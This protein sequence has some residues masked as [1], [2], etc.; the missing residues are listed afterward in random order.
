MLLKYEIYANQKS[1]K[2]NERLLIFHKWIWSVYLKETDAYTRCSQFPKSIIWKWNDT[3]KCPRT[4]ITCTKL[5]GVGSRT[6]SQD[7]RSLTCISQGT[8]YHNLSCHVLFNCTIG[9]LYPVHLL[10]Y[11]TSMVKNKTG[12]VPYSPC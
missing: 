12:L 6:Q 1:K 5:V 4:I 8:F 3:L 11:I 7:P 9:H 2:L 10:P